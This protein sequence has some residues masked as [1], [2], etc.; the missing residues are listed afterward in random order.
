MSVDVQKLV[1]DDRSNGSTWVAGYR[2]P[3]AGYRLPENSWQPSTGNRQPATGIHTGEGV[4]S[5]RE[6]HYS[7]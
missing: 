1:Q 5:D 3:V 6:S 4:R 2:L 7:R